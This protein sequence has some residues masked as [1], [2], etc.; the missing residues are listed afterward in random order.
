MS[1]EESMQK[2][3]GGD[4]W[5]HSD[6]IDLSRYLSAL[7]SRWLEILLTTLAVILLTAA[8]VLAY[9]ALTPPV[10]EAT[11][12]AAII[13][14][15]TDVVFDERFTT[16]E[17]PNLDVNSPPGLIGLVSSGSIAQQVIDE[18]GDLLPQELRRRT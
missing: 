2:S 3:A 12:T 9:R 4:R 11:T 7:A 10:Y 15:S 1:V 16:S 18:L 17:E 13:R 14:T 5:N 8:A 6:E